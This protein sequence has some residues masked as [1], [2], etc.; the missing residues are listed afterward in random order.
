MITSQGAQEKIIFEAR[1]AVL[2]GIALYRVLC[3]WTSNYTNSP[4][5]TAVC[6]LT[7]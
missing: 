6:R 5:G 3:G 2:K 7:S 4:Q 1:V